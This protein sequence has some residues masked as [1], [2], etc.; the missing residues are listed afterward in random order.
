MKISRRKP[1]VFLVLILV[2]AFLLRIIALSQFP[3]G[4]TA[5]EAAQGYT[6]Y[7]I[8]K[9]GKDEWGVRLPLSPRSFGDF[10]PPLYT[11][12]TVPSIAIFG[13]NEFAVRLPSAVF[14]VLAIFAT[15]LLVKELFQKE[16]LAL[17]AALFLAISPWHFCFSRSAVEAN[18]T[19][20]FFP[21]GLNFYLK[22]LKSS[23]Y[24]PFAALFWGLNLYTYH[25]ARLFT[26]IF[27]LFI[28]W[29]SGNKILTLNREIIIVGL[30]LA[31]FVLPVV[32]GI[33]AG[34]GGSR[35]LDV[36]LFNP[37]DRW[38]EVRTRQFESLFPFPLPRIFDNKLTWIVDKFIKNYLSYFS[39]TFLFSEGSP[40][41]SYANLPGRGLLYLWQ[42]PLLLSAIFFLYKR[43]EKMSFFLL[44]WLFLAGLPASLSKESAHANRA[45]TF[46]PL[47][48]ILSAYGAFFSW[49]CLAKHFSGLVKKVALLIC[50]M[51]LLLSLV[52]FLEDYFFHAPFKLAQGLSYGYREAINYL[53]KVEGNYDKIV[54]TKR[55]SEPQIFVAFYQKY[56]PLKYQQE[57]QDFLRYE[58][59]GWVF[60]DQMGVYRLGKYEFRDLNWGADKKLK[61]TLV[62][63][64]AEDFVIEKVIAEKT[65]YYPNGEMA[66]LIIDPEAQTKR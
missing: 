13:L 45:S 38:Q 27:L 7:S 59:E 5:D 60:L 6:A 35:F 14:G 16:K 50:F 49:D 40:D 41:I 28:I 11:Y 20:F 66:F 64:G 62:V 32:V 4:F 15:Y 30:L 65:I 54:M 43:K 42:L 29:R 21:L 2:I 61:N 8:L 56:D 9:T 24:F 31:I 44:L 10:K 3:A 58:E 51:I 47:W 37:T 48:S 39:L 1:I 55:F 12:L 52:F 26:L 36:S 22:G 34:G 19:A 25:S 18:L 46:L 17:L 23:K 33:V 57:S 63:G 53:D